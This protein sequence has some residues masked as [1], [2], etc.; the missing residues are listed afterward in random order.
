MIGTY[1]TTIGNH[2]DTQNPDL[3]ANHF[4]NA[5]KKA[6]KL[7]TTEL[8][9]YKFSGIQD[10]KGN[11]FYTRLDGDITFADNDEL[12]T[13]CSQKTATASVVLVCWAVRADA[14]KLL[15]VL[16]NDLRTVDWS[17]TQ[18]PAPVE[19]TAMSYDYEAIW[20]GELSQDPRKIKDITLVKVEFDLMYYSIATDATG[21]IDRDVC[22]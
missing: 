21:C 19:I 16:C 13:S 4:D 5:I 14:E 20:T 15:T 1:L 12:Y 2:I 22:A 10:T 9:E 11:F 18:V 6:D 17:G 7:L 8:G 3:F